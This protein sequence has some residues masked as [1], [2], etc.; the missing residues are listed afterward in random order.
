M[1]LINPYR[2]GQRIINRTFKELAAETTMKYA[3]NETS[4][5]AAAAKRGLIALVKENPKGFITQVGKKHLDDI[6]I[7]D[8]I[9]TT[10][11]TRLTSSLLCWVRNLDNS[12]DMDKFKRFIKNDM[13]T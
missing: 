8:D 6:R 10:G 5:A 12:A 3:T 11:S 9:S 2:Y 7:F 13:A 4:F 1:N